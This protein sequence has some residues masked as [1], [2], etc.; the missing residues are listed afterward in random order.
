MT[1]VHQPAQPHTDGP[2]L[3][4]NIAAVSA[5]RKGCRCTRCR[6]AIRD[7]RRRRRAEAAAGKPPRAHGRRRPDDGIVDWLVVDRLLAG[8]ATLEDATYGEALEAARRGY[9]RDGW[10]SWCDKVL[11]LRSPKIHQIAD[12]MAARVGGA[13]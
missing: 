4:P 13:A 8:Q 1:T 11:G 9:G 7:A 2:C 5:H 10:W 12:E 3:W 6:E